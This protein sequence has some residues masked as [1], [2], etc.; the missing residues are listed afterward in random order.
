[1]LPPTAKMSDMTKQHRAL[2]QCL[3]ASTR[4]LSL[5]LIG[6]DDEAVARLAV[7]Y[8]PFHSQIPVWVAGL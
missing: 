8:F 5:K 6:L 3:Q 2:S 7:S 4:I 1:R